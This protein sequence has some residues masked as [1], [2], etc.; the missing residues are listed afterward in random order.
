[1]RLAE[2]L[3]DSDRVRLILDS[4]GFDLVIKVHLARD[5]STFQVTLECPPDRV[6]D[7]EVIRFLSGGLWLLDGWLRF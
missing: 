5:L 2:A 4:C 6:L 7:H 3:K 1:M